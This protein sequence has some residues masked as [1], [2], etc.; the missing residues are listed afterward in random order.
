MVGDGVRMPRLR[1][2]QNNDRSSV[3]CANCWG[4]RE[5]QAPVECVSGWSPKAK[6]G[7]CCLHVSSKGPGLSFQIVLFLILIL[8]M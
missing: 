6:G 8:L 3:N 1:A 5:S 7:F 2:G 4:Q